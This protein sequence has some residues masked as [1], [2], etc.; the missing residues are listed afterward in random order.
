MAESPKRADRHFKRVDHSFWTDAWI[1]TLS[2]ETRFVYLALLT[3][4]NI[5]T[6]GA[7]SA[8]IPGLSHELCLSE[9]EFRAAL[10]PLLDAGKIIYN[11]KASFFWVRKF[12]KFNPL[13]TP[14]K[15][16][17]MK[18]ALQ[19]IPECPERDQLIRES[20][21]LV[22][23]EFARHLKPPFRPDDSPKQEEPSPVTSTPDH[24][25]HSIPEEIASAFPR[26]IKLRNEFHSDLAQISEG[27]AEWKANQEAL[28]RLVNDHGIKP[29][30]VCAV[31][32]FLFD[33]KEGYMPSDKFDWRLYVKDFSDLLKEKDGV[34][35]F[36][37]IHDEYKRVGGKDE[38]K[39]VDYYGK[40]LMARRKAGKPMPSDF[41]DEA[42]YLKC[43]EEIIAEGEKLRAA[44]E[45][46]KK[47]TPA[48]AIL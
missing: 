34:I 17:G 43:K 39:P 11:D 14:T 33:Q 40:A 37:K 7:L 12:L 44:A 24:A 18:T 38:P 26:L 47:P 1:K 48:E 35:R 4:P 9:S 45:R 29:H 3:H 46:K 2:M 6:L 31:V 5:T 42:D 27:N 36:T 28:L 22:A 10:Q 19:K 8:N 21:L 30:V 16:S 32:K 23:P 41:P 20:A 15:V 25:H 13:D